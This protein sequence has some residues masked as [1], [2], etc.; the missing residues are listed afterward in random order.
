MA[1]PGRTGLSRLI[2]AFGYSWLGFKACFKHEAAFRQELFLGAFMLPAAIIFAETHL[3]MAVLIGSLFLVLA[4][5]LLNS[6]LEAIVDRVGSE[7]HELSGRAKD[8]GS[9]AVTVALINVIV[10]WS[11]I[12]VPKYL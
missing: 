12:F 4:I 2:H 7:H 5:E 10:I 3:E 11:I 9:A 8:L 1:K 6:G